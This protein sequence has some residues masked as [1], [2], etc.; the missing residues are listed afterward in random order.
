MRKFIIV[1]LTLLLLPAAAGAAE[2]RAIRASSA[3]GH[4]QLEFDLSEPAEH[5]FFVLGNP[6]RLVI[7]LSQTSFRGAPPTVDDG[8]VSA[9]R[10][11]IRQGTDLRVVLDL[12]QPVAFRGALE[13]VSGSQGHR[14]V[15]SISPKGGKTASAGTPSVA[16]V[17]PK[18][19]APAPVKTRDIVVAIDAGHGGQDPGA[20]GANG[21]REKDVVLAIAKRL[22]KRVDAEPG[23]KG[24]LVRTGDYFIPLR[25]RMAIA[26][27]HKAD[28]FVSIHADAFK[29]TRARGSS[30]Y[31]LSKSGASSEAAKWLAE[32]ENAADL[33]GGVKIGDKDEVLASVLLDLSQTATMHA[34]FEAADEVLRN[35]RKIGPVHA[36]N[37]QK[38]RFVVLKSPDIPSMLVETAFISNPAEEK[39]LLN[40]SHQELL[41]KSVLDGIKRY[42]MLYPPP[43]TLL[44]MKANAEPQ[45][46]VC[47]SGDTLS[48]IANRYR[49]SLSKLRKHNDLNSD[50]IRVGQ[51]LQ[52]PIDS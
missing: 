31:I 8:L 50:V 12:K 39:K 3:D 43:G 33:V 17:A 42:F 18:V 21:S 37:V 14:L 13:P 35:L 25:K 2:V 16:P 48:A 20:L 30:V 28:F 5:H 49:V 1:L 47:A 11:G 29:D 24:V 38:A 7:D 41:A 36:S 4:T 26:R 46:H 40:G 23:M 22:Q 45:V 52:I 51:V 32:K 44:A 10:T 19:S 34:S 9:V 27:E 15:V 6:D